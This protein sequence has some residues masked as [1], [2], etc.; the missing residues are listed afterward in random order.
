MKLPSLKISLPFI[1][2]CWCIAGVQSHGLV[3]LAYPAMWAV[4]GASSEVTGGDG[5]FSNDCMAWAKRTFLPDVAWE[6]ATQSICV[7]LKPEILALLDKLL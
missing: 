6:K 5:A 2:L 4:V 3:I 1:F 7:K